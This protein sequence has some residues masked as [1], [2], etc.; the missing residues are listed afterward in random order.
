MSKNDDLIAADTITLTSAEFEA[1]KAAIARY[2]YIDKMACKLTDCRNEI[3]AAN[4]IL[5][6]HGETK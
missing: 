3:Y 5:S 6:K 4:S 1:V 2:I